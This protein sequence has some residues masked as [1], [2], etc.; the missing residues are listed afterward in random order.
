MKKILTTLLLVIAIASFGRI[1]NSA[2]AATLTPAQTAAAQQALDIMKAELLQLQA[3][4]AAQASASA[5]VISGTPPTL[6]SAL[7]SAS[8]ITSLQQGLTLLA[9]ALS[10]LRTEFVQNPQLAAG[11]EAAVLTTLKG[12]GT[13]LAMIGSSVTGGTASVPVAA[14]PA[15]P[16]P[17]SPA[18]IAQSAPTAPSTVQPLI[19]APGSQSAVT[20]EAPAIAPSADT[21]PATAEASTSWSWRNLNWP[22]VIVIVLVVLAVGLWLFWPSD[23]DDRGKKGTKNDAILSSPVRPVTMNQPMASVNSGKPAMPQQTPLTSAMASH[24][25]PNVSQ[26]QRKPA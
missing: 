1:L 9:S 26:Q 12:I 8:D 17:A 23:E 10:N 24:A 19:S 13:T 18:P 2:H 15:A 25:E 21:I 16:T 7:L 5:P 3:Q 11:H 6:N 4:A 22:L 20:P 14:A